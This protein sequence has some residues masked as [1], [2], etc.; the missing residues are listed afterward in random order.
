MKIFKYAVI[1]CFVLMFAIFPIAFGVSS[2]TTPPIVLQ[3]YLSGLTS[4][5]L[6]TNAKDGTRR[7]FIVQQGG[8]I[9]VVQPNTTTAT[10][11]MN[12]TTRVLSGGERGLLGL[13]F[14]PQFATNGYFFV[15]YTRQTDGATVISRFSAMN[16]N[17]LGNP[18]S[19]VILLTF[20]TV[21]P[22]T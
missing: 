16:S 5:L 13:A 9:K 17:T 6:A 12:I 7:L 20:L 15:N 4:P 18:N 10:D 14:H 19:E 3:P 11:F 1:C 2:Q 22:A 8:I 21:S